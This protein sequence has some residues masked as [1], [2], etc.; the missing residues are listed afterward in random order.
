[1]VSILVDLF[2]HQRQFYKEVLSKV[3]IYEYVMR[4]EFIQIDEVFTKLQLITD[5]E[6]KIPH[7]AFQSRWFEFLFSVNLYIESYNWPMG[8]CER[9]PYCCF[10]E[11]A[12]IYDRYMWKYL[13]L[14][15][16]SNGGKQFSRARTG[17]TCVELHCISSH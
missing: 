17:E 1:M 4:S 2:P 12:A 16:M 10:N 3:P 15:I 13:H 9:Y 6:D 5:E 7:G 8:V 11:D 14:Y